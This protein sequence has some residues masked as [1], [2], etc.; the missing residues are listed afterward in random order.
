MAEHR[1]LTG[2]SLHEPK[3]VEN[4]AS[5]TVYTA[6]GAGS[7]SWQTIKVV[8][9]STAPAGAEYVAT[10][11]GAEW[12]E[13]R[14]ARLA[15]ANAAKTHALTAGG[16]HTPASYVDITADLDIDGNLGF[17]IDGVTHLITIPETGYYR[18]Q[19]WIALSA[20]APSCGVGYDVQVNGVAGAPTSPVVR[21]KLKNAGDIDTLTGFG[22]KQLT[23]GDVIGIAIASDT[24]ATVTVYESVFDIKRVA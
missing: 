23:A 5:D 13:V 22:V 20:D 14:F 24:T 1:N 18:I 7:G 4:A 8:G 12:R 16:L 21:M 3:G 2:A 17:T 11:S 15:V 10:G 9:A 19:G 6:D